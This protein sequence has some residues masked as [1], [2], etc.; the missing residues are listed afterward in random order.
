MFKPCNQFNLIP[1]DYKS[2]LWEWHEV[3]ILEEIINELNITEIIESYSNTI[4]WTTAYNPRMLLKVLFY[5]YMNQTFSSRKLANKLKSDLAF[6][7]LAWNNQPDFR[8]INNFRKKKW[9]MLEKIFV[10]IVLKAK[11]LWLISFATTSVDGTKIY[12]NASKN[13]N[14]DIET[15][16]KKISK[17]FE[18]VDKIDK[19][20]DRELWEDIE[21]EI[22][23]ELKTKEWRDKKRQEIEEKKKK[24]EEKKEGVK[25]E[26]K[27]KQEAW[28]KQERINETDI[29]SRLMQMKKKDW[30]NGYNP[31]N[32]T[33]NQFI[34]VTTVT[35]SANDTNELIP[36]LK[37][38]EEKY[39]ILPEKILADK[40][41][42]TEENY[43]YW[44]EKNIA[45]YIPHPKYS[46]VN[47]DDFI[48]DKKADIYEDK[49]WNIFKFKQYV[50]SLIWRK[51]WRPRL[52]E[53]SKEEDFEAKLYFTI[54]PDGRK[55]FLQ[56]AKNLKAIFKKNDERLY[57]DEWKN[58]YKKRCCCVEPVFWNIKMNLK[59]ERFSLRWFD[60]VQIEWNLISLAHNL[61]KIINFKAS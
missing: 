34:L 61:K 56:I 16:D 19:L 31:Q 6:M 50:W 28:I 41:Y 4:R 47:L 46:W 22:P 30:W 1:Q 52:G 13:K 39:G 58:I 12:A 5:G 15:L 51:Q 53:I 32:L 18:E 43:N 44:E 17:L 33:E 40:W 54:L 24:L 2:F 48:Y 49:E 37:K 21:N 59:F 8:T 9:K 35:N 20:E 42:G 29:D 57:S 26:I 45:T 25:N 10:Q 60:G 3:I 36:V 7:Y 27:N 11:E 38:F 55:K 23:E 14:N